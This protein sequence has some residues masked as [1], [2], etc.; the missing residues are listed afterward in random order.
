M[1][2]VEFELEGLEFVRATDEVGLLRVSGRW[3]APA[4]RVLDEIVI[5]VARGPETSAHRALPD[6]DGV[7]PIASPAGGEWHGAFTMSAELAEDPRAEFFLRAG[8]DAHMELPRPGEWRGVAEPAEAAPAPPPEERVEH[9]EAP[10][11][12]NPELELLHAQL[13]EART[14]LEVERRRRESLAEEL[15]AHKAV[16]DD[17]RKAIAMQEAELASA[18]QQASQKALAAERRQLASQSGPNGHGAGGRSRPADEE[19][20]TRLERARRAGE[21]VA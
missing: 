2:A 12:P 13:H 11:G 3:F 21:A 19:F 10:S 15:R 16:E 8:A 1:V 7:A 18:A 4:N 14:E 6:P 9:A 5:S 20:L 17:L